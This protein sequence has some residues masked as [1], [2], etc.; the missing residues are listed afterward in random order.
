[1]LPE[2]AVQGP[3]VHLRVGPLN[4][5]ADNAVLGDRGGDVPAVV[6]HADL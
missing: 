3:V 1:M 2:T 5:D 4:V 6:G